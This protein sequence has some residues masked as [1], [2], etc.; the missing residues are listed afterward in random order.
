MYQVERLEGRQS[1]HTRAVGV[2]VA[3]ITGAIPSSGQGAQ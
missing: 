2:Y 1:T 3:Y